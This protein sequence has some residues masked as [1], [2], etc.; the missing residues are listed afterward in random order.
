MSYFKAKMH[1]IRSRLSLHLRA[2]WGSLQHSPG[3]LAGFKGP[4][5]K[6]MDGRK[7]MT[8]GQAKGNG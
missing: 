2:P 1:Q 5:S 6:G 8:E 4:T 7:A 3:R